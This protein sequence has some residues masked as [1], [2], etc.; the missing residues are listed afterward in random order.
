MILTLLFILFSVVHTLI[1]TR[2]FIT[3]TRN[4]P[5]FPHFRFLCFLISNKIHINNH[6]PLTLAS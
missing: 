4:P 6:S 5:P 3:P 1:L 2:S